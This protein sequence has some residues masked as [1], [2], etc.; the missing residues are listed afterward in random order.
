MKILIG[1][2]HFPPRYSGG[3]EQRALRTAAALQQRNHQVKVICVEHIDRGPTS[4]ALWQEDN[5]QGII[6]R[7][8]SFDL[9]AVPNRTI[10]EY[11][12]PWIGEQ[13]ELILRQENPDIFHLIGG[14]LLSASTLIAAR[15]QNTPSVVTLTD[16]WFICPRITLQRSDGSLSTL[17]VNPETC[18]RCLG[19][20]SR[21]YRLPGKIFPSLMNAYWHKQTEKIRQIQT[22]LDFLKTVLNNTDRII[23]PSKFLGDVFIQAGIESQR[24]TFSRQGHDFPELA[25]ELLSKTPS[26]SLRLAYMGQIAQLKGIHVLIEAVKQ[27]PNAQ[28]K[29]SIYGDETP[30]P[31]YTQKLRQIAQDDPRI[32]FAGRYQRQELTRILQNVDVVIIPSLWYENSPNIILECFAHRT[33]VIASDLGGMAELVKHNENGL[34]FTPGN[35]QSLANQLQRLLDE[36]NLLSQ[37]QTGIPPVKTLVQEINELETIYT[38]IARQ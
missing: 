7:R 4:G 38:Q 17:P 16:F 19:E 27:L 25:P 30:F 13:L 34:L 24:M 15:N 31:A 23:Y 35:P 32:E 10:F 5:Y 26:L 37:L 18:A 14:Y 12:N 36:P 22:R 11:N 28:L 29:L 20:T 3:A 21:R 1:V 33:P 6:V 8:L 9:S 2:H